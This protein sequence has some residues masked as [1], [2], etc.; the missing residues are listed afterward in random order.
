MEKISGGLGRNLVQYFP[1]TFIH[2]EV[3]FYFFLLTA[4]NRNSYLP[5]GIHSFSRI[6]RGSL[7]GLCQLKQ[8]CML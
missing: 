1:L 6:K 5:A 3:A 8:L 4:M 2:R 7:L